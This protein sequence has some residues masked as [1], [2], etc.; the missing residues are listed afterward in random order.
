MMLDFPCVVVAEAI[1]QLE[2]IERILHQTVFAMFGPRAGELVLIEDSEFHG[3]FLSMAWRFRVR[4][5]SS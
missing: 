1:G 3:E 4:R 2:L 5:L